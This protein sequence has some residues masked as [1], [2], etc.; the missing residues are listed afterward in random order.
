MVRIGLDWWSFHNSLM[1]SRIGPEDLLRRARQWGCAGVALEYFALPAAWQSDPSTLL[2]L[3]RELGLEVVFGFGLPLGLTDGA[4]RLAQNHCDRALL[5]AR[6]LGATFVRL[7]GPLVLS[8]RFT[9]PWHLRW[10]R[11]AEMRT[12][13]RRLGD[14]ARQAAEHGLAIAV[15]NQGQLDADDLLRLAEQVGAPSLRFVFHTRN[16]VE[17]G[18]DPYREANL[19]VSRLAYVRLADMIG[20]GKAARPVPLGDGRLDLP[21]LLRILQRGGFGGLCSPAVDL[22]L[23]SVSDEENWSVRGVRGIDDARL[24]LQ[25]EKIA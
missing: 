16:A 17:Q 2:G 19:L 6:Q 22:P 5:L 24:Q 4:W 8:S 12:L 20:H 10:S 14:F 21:A 13:V 15:E 11:K 3:C 18:R 23:W 9:G 1:L 25:K 7:Q